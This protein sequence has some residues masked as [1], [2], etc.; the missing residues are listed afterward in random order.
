M[1][2]FTYKQIL[3]IVVTKTTQNVSQVIEKF[4]FNQFFHN[5]LNEMKIVLKCVYY[6]HNFLFILNK[7]L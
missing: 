6:I 7:N 5:F 2:L 1:F 3:E 4:S